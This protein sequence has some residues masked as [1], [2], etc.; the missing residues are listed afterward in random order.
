MANKNI[1]LSSGHSMP[2]LGQGTW[3]IG[4]SKPMAA[5]EK[6]ALRLGIELGMTLIDT[7]EM[8]GSGKSE[9]LIGQAI[10]GLDRDGLFITSKVY[11][12]NA[13]R[14]NIF[15]S[16]DASLRRLGVD[17]LDLYLLHWPGSVPLHETVDCMEELVAKG[18]IRQWGVS[19]FDTDEMIDLWSVPK[20]DRCVVNQVL[21]HLGSRGIE[22]DLLPWMKAHKVALMAYCPLAHSGRLQQS[23]TGHPAVRQVADEQGLTPMQ[24]LLAFVLSDGQTIAIPKAANPDH[25]RDNAAVMDVCLTAEQLALL[26]AAFPAPTRKM[27][28]DIL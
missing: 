7:A 27:P 21:Y 25:V 11:P 14:R 2:R 3:Y 4:E 9:E 17:D 20:G 19:N 5:Q 23:L 6:A 15:K 10:R 12:Y 24:V 22:F 13:G 1:V 18:K 16:C 26:N 8:Y 28:L